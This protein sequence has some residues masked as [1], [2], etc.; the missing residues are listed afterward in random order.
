MSA[1][2]PQADM[3]TVSELAEAVARALEPVVLRWLAAARSQGQQ[4][5]AA[6]VTAA[7]ADLTARLG[8]RAPGVEAEEDFAEVEVEPATALPS[9]AELP[10]SL[11]NL[12]AELDGMEG[13]PPLVAF[14]R[15]LVDLAGQLDSLVD[16]P[17]AKAWL[18]ERLGD[19]EQWVF[20]PFPD[21]LLPN[22]L[23][24]RS[25]VRAALGELVRAQQDAQAFLGTRFCF[26]PI[27]PVPM[28][29]F[30]PDDRRLTCEGTDEVGRA[31]WDLRVSEVVSQGYELGEQVL[32]PAR[33]RV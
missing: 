14:G 11:P 17:D 12:L 22:E 21:A 8:I 3:Q 32:L 28:D 26:W 31:D 13:A 25:A 9:S 29:P 10:P 27:R 5:T 4:E 24:L 6:A 15:K 1:R 20:R 16:R 23:R 33:V 30:R 2:D 7:L 18:R 19:L